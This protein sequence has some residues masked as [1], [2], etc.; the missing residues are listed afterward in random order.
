MSRTIIINSKFLPLVFFLTASL[1]NGR[2]QATAVLSQQSSKAGKEISCAP[3][4]APPAGTVCD[5]TIVGR[6]VNLIGPYDD[7]IGKADFNT[8]GHLGICEIEVR[9]S[10]QS[11]NDIQVVSSTV[12]YPAGTRIKPGA[13]IVAIGYKAVHG[14]IAREV[15]ILS[16]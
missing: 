15:R 16:Y 1:M 14:F 6:V 9:S 8:R 13:R 10:D 7:G 11:V 4:A 2:A 5:G 3:N 12:I